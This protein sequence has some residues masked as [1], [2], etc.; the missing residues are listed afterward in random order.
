MYN[1]PEGPNSVKNRCF[2][3]YVDTLLKNDNSPPFKFAISSF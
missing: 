1:E 3:C 2:L